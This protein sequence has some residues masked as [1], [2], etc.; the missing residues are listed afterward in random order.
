MATI[1]ARTKCSLIELSSDNLEMADNFGI[2]EE[3]RTGYTC[4]ISVPNIAGMQGEDKR[5]M[6]EIKKDNHE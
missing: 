3:E 1:L 4:P 5:L 2:F 6:T